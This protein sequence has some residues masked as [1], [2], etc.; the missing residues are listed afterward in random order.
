MFLLE[1]PSQCVSILTALKSLGNTKPVMSID[2]CSAPTVIKAAAG[3]ANGMYWFEPY[4][5]LFAA[6]QTQDITLTKAILAKYAPAKIAVDSPALAGLSTVM[7]IWAA[8]KTTPTSK[9][10]SAYMLKTLQT[11]THPAFLCTTWNC[12]SHPIEKEPAICNADQ[13]LY[14]IK[15]TTPTL[16]T[17]GYTAGANI[18]L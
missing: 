2:P 15:G 14:Q 13:Y 1:D 11:G 8:F 5:D 12:S 16:I 10:N 17:S 6:Q 3:A 7:N 4:Q 9:L 18:G